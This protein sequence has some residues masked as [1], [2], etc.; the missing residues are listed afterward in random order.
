[1][2]WSEIQN[3][4]AQGYYIRFKQQKT[5]GAETLPISEGAVDLLGE[6]G[7]PDE[8]VFPSLMKWHT[9]YIT[10]WVRQAGIKKKI[11]FHCFRHSFAT[12]QLTLGSDISTISRMLG[13]KDIAT[14][15]IYAKIVDQK[16]REAANLITLK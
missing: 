4:S 10:D 16:K 7:P 13:H 14:T 12:L 2:V 6:R 15:Q 3:S 9:S 5:G 1:M 8:K 11:T